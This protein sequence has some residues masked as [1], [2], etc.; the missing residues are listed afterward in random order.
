MNGKSVW[1]VIILIQNAFGVLS[2]EDLKWKPSTA[3]WS[4]AQVTEHFIT[5][6][7]SYFTLF[8]QVIKKGYK[9]PVIGKIP[10]IPSA[11]GKMIL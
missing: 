5:T 8:D 7:E 2:G 4:I 1:Q 11:M 9:T 3:Q 10:L 6:N